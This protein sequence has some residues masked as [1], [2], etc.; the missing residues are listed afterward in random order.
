[1]CLSVCFLQIPVPSFTWQRID[2][3]YRDAEGKNLIQIRWYYRPKDLQHEPPSKALKNEVYYTNYFD[4]QLVESVANICK[5]FVKSEYLKLNE[6]PRRSVCEEDIFFF[7]YAYSAENGSFTKISASGN[8]HLQQSFQTQNSPK[9]TTEVS[10]KIL[11]DALIALEETLSKEAIPTSWTHIRSLIR[12]NDGKNKSNY[13]TAWKKAVLMDSSPESLIQNLEHLKIFVQHRRGSTGKKRRP[14]RYWSEDANN[15]DKLPLLQ[16][17]VCEEVDD[18]DK[19]GGRI[20]EGGIYEINNKFLPSKTPT[21]LK[22]IRAVLVTEKTNVHVSVK[23]PSILALK[24]CFDMDK[25]VEQTTP[26]YPVVDEEFVM[27]AKLAERVLSRQIPSTEYIPQRHLESFWLVTEEAP[28]IFQRDHPKL[29]ETPSASAERVP[30]ADA[31]QDMTLK[32]DVE[33]DIGPTMCERTMDIK[34][35]C[36]VARD[37]GSVPLTLK[38]GLRRKVKINRKRRSYEQTSTEAKPPEVRMSS[39]PKRRRLSLDEDDMAFSI[40]PEEKV[41]LR[42]LKLPK[43][44]QGRW[45]GERY[46]AAQLKLL[47]IMHDKGAVPGKPIFRPALREEARKHIR[48]TGLLDHLLKHMTDTVITNGERFRRRHNSEG[49]MEYWLEDASLKEIRKQ[50]GIQDPWWIPPSGWKPGDIVPL[51]GYGAGM[52]PFEAEEMRTIKEELIMLKSELNSMKS[53]DDIEEKK[54]LLPQEEDGGILTEM[55]KDLQTEIKCLRK[56][57]GGLQI[58]SLGKADVE[59]SQTECPVEQTNLS[60]VRMLR[61][62]IADRVEKLETVEHIFLQEMESNQRAEKK[63][64]EDEVTKLKEA[65]ERVQEEMKSVLKSIDKSSVTPRKEASPEQ[66]FTKASNRSEANINVG[67][68]TQNS[69]DKDTAQGVELSSEN[70]AGSV[71]QERGHSGRSG[72]RICKPEGTFIWPNMAAKTSTW[73]PVEDVLTPTQLQPPPPS[74][75]TDKSTHSVHTPIPMEYSSHKTVSCM[76]PKD[77]RDSAGTSSTLAVYKSRSKRAKRSGQKTSCHS[78]D[79]ELSQSQHKG[80]VQVRVAA[81]PAREK[82]LISMYVSHL[83]TPNLQ[84]AQMMGGQM[85]SPVP[86]SMSNNSVLSH[87]AATV[88]IQGGGA[89]GCS[90]TTTPHSSWLGLALPAA[91]SAP[92]NA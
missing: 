82:E 37:L 9:R 76:E 63:Q 12:E 85:I 45:T 80:P 19:N 1:G 87:S 24:K 27:G 20:K 64:L 91:S 11:I 88:H 74:P 55:L 34:L 68:S 28:K 57:V 52:T 16:N 38:W 69:N 83:T 7:Q 77:N 49:A 58:K 10:L 14:R 81:S 47:V 13:L 22:S 44:M 78:Q 65:L 71:H 35:L 59:T 39:Q 17:V 6:A 29:A 56:D 41:K 50:A 89:G 62:N 75:S 8:A 25:N 92:P 66:S 54:I 67:G 32:T 4:C 2:K 40:I 73:V 84:W 3:M 42:V 86:E 48:D 61:C 18:S 53:V 51:N 70:K 36:D 21:H 60:G 23:F 33:A 15:K 46:R 79:T 5:V 72:F 31:T 90:V 30:F 26:A 43:D